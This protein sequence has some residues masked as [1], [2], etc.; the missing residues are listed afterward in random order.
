MDSHLRWL[1][2]SQEDVVAAWQL[3]AAGWSCKKVRH[4][5][6]DWR[7]LHDGVF[8]LTMAPASRQQRW[9]AAVL[10]APGSVLSHGSAGACYGFYRFDKG[11]EVVTRPGKGGRRRLGAVVVCRSSCLDGDLTRFGRL[12]V[13]TA[14]RVLIDLAPGLDERRLGRA[15]REAIRLKRTTAGRVLNAVERHRGRRGTAALRVLATRYAGLPYRRTRSDAE[16]RA[17]EV[18]H[19]AGREAP[20]V[21]VKVAGVEADLVWP[22]RRLI[23]E[24]DGPQFHQFAEEDARKEQA[25]HAAGFTVRRIGSDEVYD[26][27]G[28]LVALVGGA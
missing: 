22:E 28:R 2:E 17:L 8:L 9:F 25:W 14:A 7:A 24:I 4:R 20:K 16:C 13:T 18:L 10:T 26:A 21:N 12:P 3:R 15:F 19:E 23:V 1:A 11:Y 5:S 27:A 6:R